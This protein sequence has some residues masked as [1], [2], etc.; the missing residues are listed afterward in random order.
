MDLEAKMALAIHVADLANLWLTFV[1]THLS[2]VCIT[3]GWLWNMATT[4]KEAIS[5]RIIFK[6]TS[7]CTMPW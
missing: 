2:T 7:F 6:S 5:Q 3:N 4:A 1:P